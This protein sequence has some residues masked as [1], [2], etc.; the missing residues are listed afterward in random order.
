M[1]A[2]LAAIVIGSSF[3]IAPIQIL[4]ML[5]AVTLLVT[6]TITPRR[7]TTPSAPR[8]WC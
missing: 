1:I 2:V 7:P 6:R 5:G 8:S 4:A 3:D